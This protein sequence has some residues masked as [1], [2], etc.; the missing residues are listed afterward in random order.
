MDLNISI[1]LHFLLSY[2][3]LV[4]GSQALWFG[5]IVKLYEFIKVK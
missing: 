2:Q 3:S 5:Q 1:I 4:N